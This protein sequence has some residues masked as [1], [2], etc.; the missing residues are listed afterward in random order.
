VLRTDRLVALDIPTAHG[1]RLTTVSRL[2]RGFKMS[3]K[4]MEAAR[5][6]VEVCSQ[7]TVISLGATFVPSGNDA[8]SA[9][10]TLKVIV[11]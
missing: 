3:R 5:L 8:C 6:V 11:A 2:A 7:R 10:G 4:R 1:N 9:R